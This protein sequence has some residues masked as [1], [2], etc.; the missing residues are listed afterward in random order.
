MKT[1]IITADHRDETGTFW[2]D[3]SVKDMPVTLQD[4][5]TIHDAI[6]RVIEEKDH[7]VFSY[8]GKPQGDVYQDKKDGTT[9]QTG[10]HYR[11]K[12]FISDRQAGIQTDNALFTTWVTIYGEL[13]PIELESVEE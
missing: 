2:S 3:S 13:L 10:Y 11:T 5:E 4:G 1:Y 9:V 8:K 6:K 12:H 7:C